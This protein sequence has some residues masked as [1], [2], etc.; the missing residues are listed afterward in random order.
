MKNSLKNTILI[1]SRSL[2]TEITSLEDIQKIEDISDRLPNLPFISHAIFECKLSDGVSGTDFSIYLRPPEKDIKSW[3]DKLSEVKN[4]YGNS[5]IWLRI[6]NF[7]DKWRD[8]GSLLYIGIEDIWLEFDIDSVNQSIPEPSLFF[9]INCIKGEYNEGNNIVK[10][11]QEIDWIFDSALK[12]LMLDSLKTSTKHRLYKCFKFLP[13]DSQVFQIG[14][15]LPRRSESRA[16]R[17]CVNKIKICDI[18]NYLKNIE[19][20]ESTKEIESIL[21]DIEKIVDDVALNI[22]VE[23]IVHSKIGLECYIKEYSKDSPKWQAFFNFLIQNQLCTIE[24]VNALNEWI[25]YSDEKSHR[26]LWPDSFKMGASF[27][28]PRL[29][30]TI[31]R[32]LHHV[33][34]VYQPGKSLDIKAYLW[35]GHR[36]LSVDGSFSM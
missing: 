21:N 3:D 19:C 22:S 1:T 25:G 31:V 29:R 2:G 13:V 7:I 4:Y 17:I 26:E 36:W 32:G 20:L 33:K 9:K 30:S 23:D 15:M 14:I 12:S 5:S 27:V 6:S 10:N 34:I 11:L 24:K 28:Y 35:F 18:S 8:K 16:V